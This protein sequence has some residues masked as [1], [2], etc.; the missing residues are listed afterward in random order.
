MNL[1][2]S[3]NKFEPTKIIIAGFNKGLPIVGAGFQID[4]Y[5]AVVALSGLFGEQMKPDDLEKLTGLP[6]FVS[7]GT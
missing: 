4:H 2:K 1:F 3:K 6:V 5:S 7:H